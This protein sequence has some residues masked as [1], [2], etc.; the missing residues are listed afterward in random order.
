[1]NKLNNHRQLQPDEII[2]KGDFSFRIKTCDVN[3]V[4]YSIGDTVN[5]WNNYGYTFWRRRH[6]KKPLPSSSRIRHIK[7]QVYE[8]SRQ[9]T[10][11]KP[12]KI[13]AIVKF[14]YPSRDGYTY[15]HY[16]TVQV[17]GMDDDYLWGLEIT[18]PTQ[19]GYD[20]GL[21][22]KYQFKKYLRHKMTTSIIL[23][24]YGPAN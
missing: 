1:M 18:Q 10:K 6:T 24:S 15:S 7:K 11:T 22:V 21:K 4:G 8:I 14:G 9:P 20:H 12:K 5:E 19:S 13:V 16:R 2:R 17:I 23:K 3:P